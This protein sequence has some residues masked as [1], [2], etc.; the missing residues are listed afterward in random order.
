MREVKE[1]HVRAGSFMAL[2]RVPTDAA[3]KVV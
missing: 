1:R 3:H 2:P